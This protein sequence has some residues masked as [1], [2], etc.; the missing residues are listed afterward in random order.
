MHVHESGSFFCRSHMGAQTKGLS[1]GLKGHKNI[2]IQKQS[3]IG[4]NRLEG[5]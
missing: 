4:A 5:L 1:K 2:V 3:D